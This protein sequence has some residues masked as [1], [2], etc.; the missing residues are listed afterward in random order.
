VDST[1]DDAR[2]HGDAGDEVE[3][4]VLMAAYQDGISTRSI[5][6]MGHLRPLTLPR[7]EKG[8]RFPGSGLRSALTGARS[9]KL[10]PGT[11]TGDL[12]T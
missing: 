8:V 11:A 10:S 9:Q 6:C 5:A 2:R 4:R 7:D 12:H 3:L 1:R